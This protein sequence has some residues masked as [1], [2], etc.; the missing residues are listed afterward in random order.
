MSHAEYVAKLD[1]DQLANL[2]EQAQNRVASLQQSGWV[3][4]WTVN[5][6]WAN[7]GWFAESDQ[8]AAIEFACSSI[9]AIA[10]KKP[11]ASV[12]M[13]VSLEKYRPD[14]VAGLVAAYAS[15]EKPNADQA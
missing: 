6:N 4:L 1:E 3:K 14:E 8:A 7:T 10:A 15:Q 11:G 5:V 12:E 13:N 9:K 2:I